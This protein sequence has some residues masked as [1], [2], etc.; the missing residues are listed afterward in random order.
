[1]DCKSLE[2]EMQ[3]YME[4]RGLIEREL[5]RCATAKPMERPTYTELGQ[6]VGIPTRGP[7]QPVLDAIANDADKANE[8]DL[9]FLIRN[10]RTGYPSRIGRVTKKNPL[11]WQKERARDKI[12]EIIDKYNPETP[13][14]IV[15]CQIEPPKGVA[16]PS[17]IECVD[18][19]ADLSRNYVLKVP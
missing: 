12:Q 9:T 13:N 4:K 10:A 5:L 14:P 8:P 18:T 16:Q 3:K 17:R 15:V 6:R 11:P 1:L 2:V 19:I 7:W